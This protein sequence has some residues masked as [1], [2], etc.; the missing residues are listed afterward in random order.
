MFKTATPLV[1]MTQAELEAII[2][3]A[4]R[5]AIAEAVKGVPHVGNS[6]SAAKSSASALSA[7]RAHGDRIIR[8]PEVM[9]ML[10]MKKTAIYDRI[11]DGTFPKPI[12]LG[13]MSGW[14]RSD[15]LA[16][17]VG[18]SGQRAA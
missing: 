7:D 1:I 12:K 8:V 14:R 13:R 3:H 11:K 6:Q 4:V 15:V 18:Q 5:K 16:W 9:E 17:I 10:G 2:D